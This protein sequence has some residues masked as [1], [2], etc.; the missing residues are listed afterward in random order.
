LEMLPWPLPHPSGAV[1]T[2]RH[3]KTSQRQLAWWRAPR[4]CGAPRDA[5][6]DRLPAGGET[7]VSVVGDLVI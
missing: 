5:R 1:P 3:Q 2:R 7:V 6:D 4:T